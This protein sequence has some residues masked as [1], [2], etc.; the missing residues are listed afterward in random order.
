MYS[1]WKAGHTLEAFQLEF[2]LKQ[3][4]P[5]LFVNPDIGPAN[6]QWRNAIKEGM[7]SKIERIL[8]VTPG[9]WKYER[10]MKRCRMSLNCA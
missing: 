1:R 5:A 4:C 9:E 7:E 8:K 2:S 3:G 10:E 6:G